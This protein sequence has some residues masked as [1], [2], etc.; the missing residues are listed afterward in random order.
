MRPFDLPKFIFVDITVAVDVDVTSDETGLFNSKLF[1]KWI[2][3][4]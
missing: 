4:H 2:Y 1:L 3:G